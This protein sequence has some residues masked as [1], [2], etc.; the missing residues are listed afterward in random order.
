MSES[1][2]EPEVPVSSY[3]AQRRADW[4]AGLQARAD[5]MT[6]AAMQAHQPDHNRVTSGQGGIFGAG[7]TGE[8]MA[9]EVAER[10][11]TVGTGTDSGRPLERN[12]GLYDHAASG[13]VPS[14]VYPSQLGHQATGE[15]MSPL[16]RHYRGQ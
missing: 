11:A 3:G 15:M 9:A 1:F 16:A 2:N 7:A 5:D 8:R 10:A 4:L 6:Q 13:P 14:R 12:G